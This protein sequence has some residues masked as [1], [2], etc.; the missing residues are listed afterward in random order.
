MNDII[1]NI[2]EVYRMEGYT[3]NR[4]EAI[5]INDAIDFA[6]ETWTKNQ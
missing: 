6:Y 4:E 2:I 1:D 5:E 3:I